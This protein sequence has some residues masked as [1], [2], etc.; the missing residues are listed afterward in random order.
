MCL[1]IALVFAPSTVGAKK[2][3]TVKGE[4]LRVAQVA[5]VGV[6][7]AP[8]RVLTTFEA[9]GYKGKLAVAC[10]REARPDTAAFCAVIDERGGVL[11]DSLG[12]NVLRTEDPKKGDHLEL[13]FQAQ[14]GKEVT[15]ISTSAGLTPENLDAIGKAFQADLSMLE[16]MTG[17]DAFPVGVGLEGGAK[18]S[19]EFIVFGKAA[20]TPTADL[21]AEIKAPPE[22]EPEPEPVADA[23]AEVDGND[24]APPSTEP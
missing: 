20:T 9:P 3:Q 11:D 17:L 4:A 13:L 12:L 19:G 15:Y 6:E 21:L 8:A 7:R 22:P 10:A 18:I 24:Q 2:H 23:R 5:E 14:L 16:F 1:G